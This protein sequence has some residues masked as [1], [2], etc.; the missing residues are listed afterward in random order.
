MLNESGAEPSDQFQCSQQAGSRLKTLYSAR[1]EELCARAFETFV[2]DSKPN[3]RFLVSSTV[4]SDEAKAGLYPRS[5]HRAAVNEAFEQYFKAL[6]DALY[7]EG[8]HVG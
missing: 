5:Q 4:Y 3:N 1:P 6:G 8:V 2:E 7:R